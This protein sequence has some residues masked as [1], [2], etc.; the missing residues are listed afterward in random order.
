VVSTG[1]GA[2]AAQYYAVTA[3]ARGKLNQEA[4]VLKKRFSICRMRR[5]STA[6]LVF[7]TAGWGRRIRHR[8]TFRMSKQPEL[9]FA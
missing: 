9:G 7:C 1:D 5:A 8:S 6:N 3:F 2:L 4:R